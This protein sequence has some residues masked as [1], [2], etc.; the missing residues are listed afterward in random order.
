MRGQG[1]RT[2]SKGALRGT[3]DPQ[4]TAMV[5][6]PRLRSGSDP[7]PIISGPVRPPHKPHRKRLEAFMPQQRHM[8]CEER[9][10][11][12]CPGAVQ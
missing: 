2:K 10:F 8:F 12:P 7:S 9:I 6:T 1:G 11:L 4:Q 5:P 3:R